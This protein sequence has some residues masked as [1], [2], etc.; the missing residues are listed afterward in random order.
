MDFEELMRI[1]CIEVASPHMACMY[2]CT[3]AYTCVEYSAL[4]AGRHRG[5]VNLL[6]Q[7]L[8]PVFGG[9]QKRLVSVD[10]HNM[11]NIVLM[12]IFEIGHSIHVVNLASPG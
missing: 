8:N 1:L 10:L 4:L 12:A 2:C 5:W 3:H 6:D 11:Y 7:V 9:Y